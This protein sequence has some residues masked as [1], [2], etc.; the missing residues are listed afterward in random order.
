MDDVR[1]LSD[2]VHRWVEQFNAIPGAMI[3]QSMS[4]DE[5]AWREITVPSCGDRVYVY[6]RAGEGEL[7]GREGEGYSVRMDSGGEVLQ[8]SKDGFEVMYYD[9]LPMWG[10]M[11]S[12]GSWL[13]NDWLHDYGGLELMSR[14]GFRIYEHDE[15]GTFFGIDGAGYDFYEAHWIP[16]YRSRGLEWHK[17]I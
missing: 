14:C 13:D 8:V 4:V 9:A 12:F 1:K 16:L 3:A 10:T 2:A 6:D 11:W 5:D 15:F 17:F 7:L